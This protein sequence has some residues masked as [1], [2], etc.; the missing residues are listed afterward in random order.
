MHSGEFVDTMA[1]YLAIFVLFF[2]PVEDGT[3]LAR[4][5]PGSTYWS[6]RPGNSIHAS[7]SLKFTQIDSAIEWLCTRHSVACSPRRLDPS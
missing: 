6:C 7:S 4:A 2:V 5:S 3:T 1:D